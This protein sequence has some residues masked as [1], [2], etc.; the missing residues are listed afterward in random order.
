MRPVVIR[1]YVESGAVHDKA[2]GNE[3]RGPEGV[4]FDQRLDQLGTSR[5]DSTQIPK[6]CLSMSKIGRANGG[7]HWAVVESMGSRVDSTALTQ[8]RSAI[9]MLEAIAESDASGKYS[10]STLQNHGRA[11]ECLGVVGEGGIGD[12]ALGLS[13]ESMR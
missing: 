11:A 2:A 3:A 1:G 10:P 8:S 9:H 4:A 13:I 7:V 5:I 12:S 6:D